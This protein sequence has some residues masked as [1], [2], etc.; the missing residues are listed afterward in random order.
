MHNAKA[1]EK[2]VDR[3]LYGVK[4]YTHTTSLWICS[5]DCGM[6]VTLLMTSYSHTPDVYENLFRYSIRVDDE[7]KFNNN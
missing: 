6:C 5:V 7:L 2:G 3:S 4:I 1:V